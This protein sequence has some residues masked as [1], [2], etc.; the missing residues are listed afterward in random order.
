MFE[1]QDCSSVMDRVM[2]ILQQELLVGLQLV[3][4]IIKL[5]SQ[6]PIPQIQLLR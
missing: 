3:M 4:E 6:L 1:D 5:R 2:H